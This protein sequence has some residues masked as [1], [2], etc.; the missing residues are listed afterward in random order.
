M[1]IRCFFFLSNFTIYMQMITTAHFSRMMKHFQN[2]WKSYWNYQKSNFLAKYKIKVNKRE[3]FT[4][5]PVEKR[6]CIF[7]L[8]FEACKK[9]FH[10]NVA[11]PDGGQA[12]STWK[13]SYMRMRIW[14]RKGW[15]NKV[16]CASWSV[17]MEFGC[18]CCVPYFRVGSI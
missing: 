13:D 12:T 10:Q 15:K 9:P 18:C 4:T 1:F 6:C 14:R 17:P 3:I 8:A 16:K 7:P 11:W 2:A 5:W